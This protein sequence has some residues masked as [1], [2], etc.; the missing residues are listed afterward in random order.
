MH[1]V[2]IME[3]FEALKNVIGVLLYKLLVKFLLFI[4]A[5]SNGKAWS[6][7][8]HELDLSIVEKGLLY[9]NEIWM[10]E[11]LKNCKLVRKT[12]K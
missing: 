5:I 4:K 11:L 6:M 1:Y 7:F 2:V 8:E 9:L 10:S 3:M 12:I